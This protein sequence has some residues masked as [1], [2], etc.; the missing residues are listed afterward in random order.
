MTRVC[1]TLVNISPCQDVQ[2]GL[3]ISFSSVVSDL[4]W[5]CSAVHNISAKI[6][7]FLCKSVPILPILYFEAV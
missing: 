2:S 3:S 4:V 1:L 5:F 6:T 7:T